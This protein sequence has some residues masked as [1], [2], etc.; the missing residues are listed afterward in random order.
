MINNKS[1]NK[2]MYIIIIVLVVVALASILIYKQKTHTYPN[3][4]ITKEIA[5]TIARAKL[6]T[7]MADLL[8]DVTFGLSGEP[9]NIGSDR[10]LIEFTY[11]PDRTPYPADGKVRNWSVLIVVDPSLKKVAHYKIGDNEIVRESSDAV[12]TYTA[13]N[14]RYTFQYPEFPGWEFYDISDDGYHIFLHDPTLADP[15]DVADVELPRIDI[16]EADPLVAPPLG[17]KEYF[18]DIGKI[19]IGALDGS[20]VVIE[21]PLFEDHGFSSQKMADMIME[22]IRFK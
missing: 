4:M 8:D 2:M 18:Q 11:M 3:T 7:L 16:S 22:T 15:H 5:E 13:P 12:K 14:G 6:D 1:K 20:L 21:I 19:N 17:Y 10:E 9:R